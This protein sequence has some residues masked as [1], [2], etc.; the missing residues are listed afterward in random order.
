MVSVCSNETLTKT[1]ALQHLCVFRHNEVCFHFLPAPWTF[2]SGCEVIRGLD[3]DSEFMETQ[4]GGPS[5]Q[6]RTPHPV[7]TSF[8][9]PFSP[10]VS[11]ASGWHLQVSATVP[12]LPGKWLL[13]VL[14][15]ASA[16]TSCE[17][18]TNDFPDLT[19][20]LFLLLK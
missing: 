6:V 2:S 12:R 5:D 7:L 4:R 20:C 11:P 14:I 16:F 9:C 8:L 3:M 10:G 13:V 18:L 1:H 15:P 17:V 19:T